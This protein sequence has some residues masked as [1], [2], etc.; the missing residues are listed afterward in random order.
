MA[1]A[2][3]AQHHPRDRPARPLVTVRAMCLLQKHLGP[4]VAPAELVVM[5]KVF[6]EMPRRETALARATQGFHPSDR[7]TGTRFADTPEP[8]IQQP[9]SP[10]SS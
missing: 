5:H 4:C 3:L 9:V 1:R 2:I 7:S 6:V 10:A 8:A